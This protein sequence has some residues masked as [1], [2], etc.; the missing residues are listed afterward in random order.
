[1]VAIRS[2]D[3]IGLLL[4]NIIIASFGKKIS[5]IDV[6]A[7][8]DFNEAYD[9]RDAL[10]GFPQRDV[11]LYGPEACGKLVLVHPLGFPERHQPFSVKCPH[12]FSFRPMLTTFICGCQALF[13]G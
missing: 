13:F 9:G 4:A 7:I 3:T 11:L 2:S 8:T 6:I 12:G 1:M 10:P 5:H